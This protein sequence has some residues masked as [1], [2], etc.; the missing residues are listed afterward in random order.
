MR[1]RV[2]QGV[3]RVEWVQTDRMVADMFTKQLGP[4]KL[5]AMCEKIGLG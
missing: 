2:Q 3:L 4:T 5:K 1:E